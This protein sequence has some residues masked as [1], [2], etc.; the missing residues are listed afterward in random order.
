MA[1][2]LPPELIDR[3]R[4]AKRI[5]ASTGAGI[6]A[7]SGLSTFRDKQTGLWAKY[8]PEDLATPQAFQR[9]PRM[10]WEWYEWR[11]GFVAEAQPNPGH[12]ALAQIEAA[13]PGFLLVTQNVDGLHT[14]AG[15]RNLVELHGNIRRSICFDR[16]H[17]AESW[18]P[19]NNPPPLCAQCGSPLRPD[20][21]WFGEAL[22]Q[23]AL[24][25]AQEAAAN[26]D[27]FLSIGTSTMVYPAA[28]LPF[29]AGS[30]GATVVEINPDETPL[31]KL[32]DYVVRE[33]AGVALPDIAAAM[34]KDS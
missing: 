32:A 25:R 30:N 5:V 19:T 10:V 34:A 11:R 18:A 6:S 15:S 23:E 12:H 4:T 17:V 22:P 27:L 14:K 31:S 8:R 20:V 16:R 9:D 1:I 3:L 28:E 2:D 21:V 29:I 13:R 26:C 33:K 24:R 7:E